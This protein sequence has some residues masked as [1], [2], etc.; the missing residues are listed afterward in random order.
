MKRYDKREKTSKQN[1]KCILKK[2]EYLF[3]FRNQK[4]RAKRQGL[5]ADMRKKYSKYIINN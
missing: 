3:I 1:I 2:G 4:R 5:Y